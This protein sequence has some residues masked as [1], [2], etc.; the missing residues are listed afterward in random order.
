M[1]ADFVARLIGMIV[2]SIFGVY[3]GAYLGRLANLSPG[4]Y[5]FS[6]EQYAFTIGLVGALTGLILT[7]FLSTRPLRLPQLLG[8][9]SPQS[10]FA[11]LLGLIVGLMVAAL[12]AFP[13]SLLPFAVWSGHAFYWCG[14]FGISGC[15]G[16][17]HAAE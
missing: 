16:I 14:H 4:D 3:L 15:F 7:P 5:T 10:L 1:S 9:I 12:L 13:L 11:S 17:C 6:V 8:R 2:F